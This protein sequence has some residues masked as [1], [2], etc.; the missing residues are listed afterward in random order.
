MG[1]VPLILGPAEYRPAGGF[2]MR[3][4]DSLRKC[5][6]FL[7]FAD[8]QDL[9]FGIN[10]VG[11][12]FLLAM[13]G[14]GYLVTARHVARDLG[15][16]GWVAR[17]NRK[18]GSCINVPVD[19]VTWV[20]HPNPNV[21]L[22]ITTFHLDPANF[23]DLDSIYL[24]DA[25]VLT[26][27][28]LAKNHVGIGDPCFTIGLFHFL[29]GKKRNLPV[30]H[31]GNISLLPGDEK[32]P[33]RDWDD[34]TKIRHVE[35]YLVESMSMP[36]LS[37]SP[38]FVRPTLAMPGLNLK[39]KD[40]STVADAA[41]LTRDSVFLLGVFQA[42]WQAPPSEIVAIDRGKPVV[43]P[44]GMGIVVPAQRIMEILDM[45]I[46]KDPREARKRLIESAEAATPSSLAPAKSEPRSI[47]G[48]EQH[49]E[50]FTALLDA[51]V[52]KPRQAG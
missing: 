28:A 19:V 5:V 22:A 26:A 20:S 41:I 47:E 17:I 49:A 6:V 34:E 48:D 21:D 39:L 3:I 7:G 29:R 36:G 44:V 9:D 31:A 27:D 13:D 52:G 11:T 1:S 8:P 10:C 51:A 42:A 33:M 46:L 4:N 30:V 12:G 18:D 14:A 15:D 25:N 38:V 35:A 43:V 40:G 37:G 24:P 32:V 45:P 23:S 50:R 2:K 16:T